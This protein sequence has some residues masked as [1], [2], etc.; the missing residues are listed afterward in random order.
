VQRHAEN[1]YS[2]PRNLSNSCLSNLSYSFP[3]NLSYS[4]RTVFLVISRTVIS[5]TVALVISRTVALAISRTVFLAISRT[6]SPRHLS[7]SLA[8]PPPSHLPFSLTHSYIPAPLAHPSLASL[9]GALKE[10]LRLHLGKGGKSVAP[11]AIRTTFP[12]RVIRHASCAAL[13]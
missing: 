3:S 8:P 1:S 6:F 2:F 12:A 7:T 11:F 10:A 9:A 5:R 13:L 4:F